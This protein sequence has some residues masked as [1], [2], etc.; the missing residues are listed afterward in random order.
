MTVKDDG[1]QSGKPALDPVTEATRQLAKPAYKDAVK[2]LAQQVGQ[3]GATIGGVVNL[4]L[5]PVAI[6]VYAY[7]QAEPH[8]KKRIS[9]AVE[10][11]LAD[12]PP[13]N[14]VAPSQRIAVP[15]LQSLV[16]ASDEPE[17][18]DMFANLLASSM[19]VDTTTNVHPSFVEIIN[20]LTADEAR[21]LDVISSQAMFPLVDL[22]FHRGSND[23]YDIVLKNFNLLSTTDRYKRPDLIGSYIDNLCR[24]GLVEVPP[25][26]QMADKEQYKKLEE[27][28]Q[29]LAYKNA[30]NL[31]EDFRFEIERKL[32]R[33]TTYGRQFVNVAIKN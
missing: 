15:I 18:A 7:Q 21:L 24:L 25:T 11:R 26:I 9:K 27:H 20:S 23:G 31:K 1:V 16:H 17:I 4:L 12:V 14:I 28:P 10:K 33:L 32:I 22:Q 6:T 8:L 30:S 5:A 3:A 29:V 19:N 13:E 2:P